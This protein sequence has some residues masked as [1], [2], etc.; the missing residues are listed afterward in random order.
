[1]TPERVGL[2]LADAVQ[3][4]SF[5][6]L[7]GKVDQLRSLGL[8][9]EGKFKR[10]NHAFHLLVGFEPIQLPTIHLLN[11]VDAAALDGFGNRTIGQVADRSFVRRRA[12]TLNRR[13]LMNRRQERAAVVALAF[14]RKNRDLARQLLVFRSE[15]IGQPRT[16]R[17]NDIEQIARM[18]LPDGDRMVGAVRLDRSQH[19]QVVRMLCGVRQQVAHI[20][21]ALASVHKARHRPS[22]RVFS[23]PTVASVAGS[24]YGNAWPDRFTSCGLK[25]NK[26]IC[27]GPPD[28]NRK[29]MR[30][31][32][33]GKCVGLTASGD[34][35]LF[36]ACGEAAA[37]C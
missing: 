10:L 37:I 13:A 1:L 12:N 24:S 4:L 9:L 6:R 30:L 35:S 27:D 32:R 33:A 11:Q 16:H 28:M 18:Q 15:A 14:F 17:R 31:A 20:Q 19:T 8:H 36:A 22:S 26:S 23:R 3:G 29:M 5:F 34:A 21:A 7:L 2:L 25:S